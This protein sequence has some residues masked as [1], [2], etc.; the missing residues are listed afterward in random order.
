MHLVYLH[1]PYL[2]IINVHCI[3]RE[4]SSNHLFSRKIFHIR[5]EIL[6]T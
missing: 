4:P 6:Q 1:G 3:P 2:V 5:Y